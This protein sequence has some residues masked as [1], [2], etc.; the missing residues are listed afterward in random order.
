M[1]LKT[2]LFYLMFFFFLNEEKLKKTM[3]RKKGKFYV[4]NFINHR[5]IFLKRTF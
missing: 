3:S 4:I 2:F 5:I 1:F